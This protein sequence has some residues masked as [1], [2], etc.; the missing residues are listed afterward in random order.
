MELNKII[1][2]GKFF[3]ISL[4]L[5]IVQILLYLVEEDNV[6]TARY[7]LNLCEVHLLNDSVYARP[8]SQSDGSSSS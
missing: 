3:F 4:N 1:T 8:I 7:T 6:K 2:F 5:A